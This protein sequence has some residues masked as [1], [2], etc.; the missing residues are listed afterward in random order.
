MLIHFVHGEKG[1]VGKSWFARLLIDCCL[2]SGWEHLTVIESDPS[3]PDV[4]CYFPD[5]SESIYFSEDDKRSYAPDRIFLLAESRPVIVNL[6]AQVAV[7]LDDWIDRNGLLDEDFSELQ[8]YKW[9]VCTG[10]PDSVS[11][12]KDSVQAFDG[13]IRHILVK[14]MGRTGAHEVTWNRL[15]ADSELVEF[16]NAH[17]VIQMVLDP[18]HA[19]DADVI[20]SKR[21]TFRQA[22]GEVPSDVNLPL[23]P[24]RRLKLYREKVFTAIRETGLIST[25]VYLKHLALDKA[26]PPEDNSSVPEA[27]AASNSSKNKKSK[28]VA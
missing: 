16:V 27:V 21:V 5:I 22:I 7:P 13:K 14:N 28:S 3:N 15:A 1:G 8:I 17:N 24:K 12:F 26:L 25:D 23:L 10:E 18:L 9:F 2:S 6:P 4:G 11:L 20:I 19:D